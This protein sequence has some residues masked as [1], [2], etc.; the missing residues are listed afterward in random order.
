MHALYQNV[1]NV[2]LSIAKPLPAVLHFD[3]KL[4]IQAQDQKSSMHILELR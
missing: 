4:T 3:Q 2:L 1:A